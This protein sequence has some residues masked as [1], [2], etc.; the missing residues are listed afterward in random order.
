MPT[1]ANARTQ[2]SWKSMNIAILGYFVIQFSQH[3]P[4]LNPYTLFLQIDLSGI[5]I[6]KIKHNKRVAILGSEGEA[7]II[8]A[9][10]LYPVSNPTFLLHTI[11]LLIS[12]SSWGV[13]MKRGSC[14]VEFS[15]RGFFWD[16]STRDESL[17]EFGV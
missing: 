16:N 1:R 17:C 6:V 9:T 11:T 3:D 7:I 4:C 12:F 10:T 13:T 8:M 14:D 5:K 15:H 2:S